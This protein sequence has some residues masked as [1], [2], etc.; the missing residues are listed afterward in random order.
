MYDYKAIEKTE[1]H[2]LVNGGQL[3]LVATHDGQGGFDIAPIAWSC[4]VKKEPARFLITVGT[5]HQTHK[6]IK[7]TGEFVLCA[8]HLSQLNLVKKTGDVS[9]SEVDKYVQFN[10]QSFKAGHS[11]ILIPVGIV[12]YIECKLVQEFETEGPT[13][14][15]GEGLDGAAREKAFEGRLLVENEEAR[16][17]H[18]LGNKVFGTMTGPYLKY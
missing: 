1:L 11:D 14:F 8:P 17:L 12:G 15:I 5:R 16:T 2:R 4:P 7:A 10:I 6:N 9:G 3:L 18:H 13:L